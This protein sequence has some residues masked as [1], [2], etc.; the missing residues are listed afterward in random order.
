MHNMN[1]IIS[2]QKNS[3][4]NSKNV[5]P[6]EKSKQHRGTLLYKEKLKKNLSAYIEIPV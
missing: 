4:H 2:K 5:K 1:L 6:I 3:L